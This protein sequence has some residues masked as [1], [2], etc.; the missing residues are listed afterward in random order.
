M[1]SGYEWVNYKV[2]EEFSVFRTCKDLVEFANVAS[3]LESS[4]N[5]EIVNIDFCEANENV[6][7]DRE[8]SEKVF[9][10]YF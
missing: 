3:I 4:T 7:H 2:L 1:R 10:F 6:C 8:G 5:G 9:F